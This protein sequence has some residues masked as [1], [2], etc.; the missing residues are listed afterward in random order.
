M[1][2]TTDLLFD[3]ERFAE[4]VPFL[5]IVYAFNGGL[6][7]YEHRMGVLYEAPRSAEPGR[8]TSG[9]QFEIGENV[10]MM[11]AILTTLQGL[12][13]LRKRLDV[14]IEGRGIHVN[15]AVDGSIGDCL[16]DAIRFR[17]VE[18]VCAGLLHIRLAPGLNRPVKGRGELSRGIGRG[19]RRGRA[20]AC[21]SGPAR[22]LCPG[23]SG[24]QKNRHSQNQLLAC[25]VHLES[26]SARKLR[27]ESS[28]L[29]PRGTRRRTNPRTV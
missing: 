7:H 10:A 26:S 4:G 8:I 28:F 22:N 13:L 21:R 3:C 17:S 18:N 1:G 20:W 14:E 25:E 9:F 2:R 19:C 5:T 11:G 12:A 6:H 27:G 16:L 24:E 29:T 15:L 23:K